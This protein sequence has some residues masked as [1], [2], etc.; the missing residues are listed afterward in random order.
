MSLRGYEYKRD[1]K[2]KQR[3]VNFEY[4]LKLFNFWDSEVYQFVFC[5]TRMGKLPTGTLTTAAIFAVTSFCA[6]LIGVP[7]ML[8]DVANLHS[9]LA[10]Q[11]QIYRDMVITKGSSHLSETLINLF[12]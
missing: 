2:R 5:R 11:H 10:Q 8:N 9:E 1:D 7:V 6:L 12:I 4:P 3:P